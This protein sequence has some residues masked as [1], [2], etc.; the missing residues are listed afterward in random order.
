MEKENYNLKWTTREKSQ[1]KWKRRE[2]KEDDGHQ[3]RHVYQPV[4][5]PAGNR[6]EEK[7]KKKL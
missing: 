1:N 6:D 3:P 7:G 2:K 4:I 5:P